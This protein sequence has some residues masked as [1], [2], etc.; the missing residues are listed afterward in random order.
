MLRGP[1]KHSFA[2]RVS[3]A[4]GAVLILLV[5][6][7]GG[8][9]SEPIAGDSPQA[10]AY[11]GMAYDAARQEVVLFGGWNGS[12]YLDD[13]WT[14]DGTTWAQRMPPTSP[15]VRGNFGMAYDAARGEVV[16]F[17]GW[18]GSTHL[19][20]TWS[21]DGVTW[22]QEAPPTSPSAR[23]DHRMVFDVVRNEV[24][25]FGGQGP[26]GM[27]G[28]T[29]TW[30]GSSWTQESPPRSPEARSLVAMAFDEGFYQ[31]SVMIFGGW[32]G[33]LGY[34]NETWVWNGQT[35]KRKYQERR[36]PS[37]RASA[38]IAFDAASVETI[39]FGGVQRSGMR[40]GDTWRWYGEGKWDLL[41]PHTSP[42]ER[43]GMGMV[44]ARS[45][46]MLFGGYGPPV[47]GDT[48]T[49]DGVTWTLAD[50]G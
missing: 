3:A 20:D 47:L 26:L 23:Y 27:L 21:W 49:W 42:S 7:A 32:D 43:D 12:A 33:A 30:D 16:L 24:M 38:G 44:Y 22:T 8:S 29:W 39:M 5:I 41:H 13:T 10:R 37:R 35:W 45:T 2:R 40:L 18:S 11:M 36:H 31:G 9:A 48:W 50:P 6:P 17:G 34:L 28:D 19:S 25:L 1:V 4:V 46:I 14:W 15:G